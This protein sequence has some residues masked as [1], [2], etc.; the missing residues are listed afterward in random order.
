MPDGHIGRFRGESWKE[1]KEAQAVREGRRDPRQAFPA[2]SDFMDGL[3]RAVD[4]ANRTEIVSGTYGRWVPAERWADAQPAS[5]RLPDGLT[6][7]GLP[8]IEERV[9]RRGGMVTVRAANAAGRLITYEEPKGTAIDAG[10]FAPPLAGL[11]DSGPSAKWARDFLADEK[12]IL[13]ERQ[14]TFEGHALRVADAISGAFIDSLNGTRTWAESM[15]A[16]FRE[17]VN[18][19]IRDLLRMI[20]IKIVAFAVSPLLGVG[21]SA[22]DIGVGAGGVAGF[23]GVVGAAAGAGGGVM[24]TA[25]TSIVINAVDA[26]S[27][28]DALRRNDSALVRVVRGLERSGRFA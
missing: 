12:Q 7:L 1:S 9:V 26:R 4:I 3:D 19:I 2:M 13:A 11:I 28:E 24:A 15:K 17:L 16:L 21:S 6:R 18:A 10:G 5:H 23:G 8:V 20:A 22:V 14:A 25:G 27:F